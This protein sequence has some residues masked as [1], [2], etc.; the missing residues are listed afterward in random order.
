MDYKYIEQLIE[1]Y[2]ACETS[3]QEE[4]ILRSFF[5][6]E[7]VPANLLEYA[8][9]FRY[10]VESTKAHLGE[11]FDK[12]MMDLVE[13]EN[14]KTTKVV[15]MR[16]RFAPLFKAAA[17]VAIVLTIGNAAERSISSESV[18]GMESATAISPYIKRSDISAAIKVKDNSQAE[19]K[20]VANPADSVL[21]EKND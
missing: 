20:P 21:V 3:L 1:R 13:K 5:A 2:F 19:T 8:E 10:E 7:D 4:Q 16:S 12:K 14:A 6:Q 18:D 17:I 11:D 9:I 15:K